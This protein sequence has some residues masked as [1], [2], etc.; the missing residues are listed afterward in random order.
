MLMRKG[1]KKRID[2]GWYLENDMCESHDLRV[3]MLVL[4]QCP[5]LVGCEF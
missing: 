2:Q 3:V 1:E 5:K 4:R